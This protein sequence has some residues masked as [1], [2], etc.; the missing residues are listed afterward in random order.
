MYKCFNN[1]PNG[2]GGPNGLG[3]NCFLVAST[4]LE[5]VTGLSF[6]SYL[7]PAILI[8]KVHFVNTTRQPRLHYQAVES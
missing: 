2:L 8:I 6:G 5:L 4:R 7:G 1:T 3:L